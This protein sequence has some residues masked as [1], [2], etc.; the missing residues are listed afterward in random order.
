[1]TDSVVMFA[2]I[3]KWAKQV[4]NRLGEYVC[5]T[6]HCIDWREYVCRTRYCKGWG[7][8]VCGTGYCIDWRNMFVEHGIV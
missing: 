1:M 4:L 6:G 8:Y 2:L 3:H 5:G 7:E